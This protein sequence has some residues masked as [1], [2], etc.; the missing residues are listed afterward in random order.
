MNSGIIYLMKSS[1]IPGI[2]KIGK[3]EEDRF[4][5]RMRIFRKRGYNF[6]DLRPVLAIAVDNYS[7]VEKC[8]HSKFEDCRIGGINSE[9]FNFSKREILNQVKEGFSIIAK[10]GEIIFKFGKVDKYEISKFWDF[11]F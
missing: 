9:I 7:E 3:S 4:V 6:I 11:N 8:L 10:D 5:K 2:F 1:N